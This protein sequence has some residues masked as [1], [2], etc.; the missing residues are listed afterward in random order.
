MRVSDADFSEDEKAEEAAKLYSR[1][2]REEESI[3]KC[4]F[5]KGIGRFSATAVELNSCEF[6]YT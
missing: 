1:A 3:A 6:S 4:P 2:G 5:A